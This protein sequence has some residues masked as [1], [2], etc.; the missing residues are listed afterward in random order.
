MVKLSDVMVKACSDV[1]KPSCSLESV[2]VKMVKSSNVIVS[3]CS[4]VEE[5]AFPLEGEEVG[6][7]KPSVAEVKAKKRKKRRVKTCLSKDWR[8]HEKQGLKHRRRV[9]CGFL[10]IRT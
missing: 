5:P 6:V 8:R 4:A 9:D 10:T 3:S 7:V 2:E 1:M